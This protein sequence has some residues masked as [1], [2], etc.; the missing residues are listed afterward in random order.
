MGCVGD[1]DDVVEIVFTRDGGEAVDLLL[2]VDGAGFGDDAAEGDSIG[3]EVVAAD[4][5]LGVAGVFVAAAAEGDDQGSDVLAVEFDGVIEAGVKDGG[6]A[7]GVFG[8]AEDGDGVGGLGV[9][10]A[11]DG[12]YLLIDPEAPCRGGE[13]DQREQPTEEGTACGASASQIGGGGDH[14]R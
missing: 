14:L 9:V 4:A 13:E 12:G 2:G 6:W 7:A 11:G 3:E 8:R 5:S 10:F 1:Y